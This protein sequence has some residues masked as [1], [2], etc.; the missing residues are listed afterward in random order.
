MDDTERAAAGGRAY[1]HGDLRHVLIETAE[2][3]LTERGVEGFSLRECARRAGVSP[4]APAHHF[5]NVTG[6]L[7]AIATLGFEGLCRAM[8][9]AA[10]AGATPTARL[11]GLGRG[12]IRYALEHPAR[13]RV[14]FGRFP[15]ERGDPALAQA[16][17][18]AFGLLATANEALPG[19]GGDASSLVLAWS[20]VHGFATLAL[21]GQMP[22]VDGQPD[23]AAAI[24]RLADGMLSLIGR[25]LGRDS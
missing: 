19:R 7:T 1:H 20:A 18:R 14:M 22:F 2:Q 16:G 12:Y 21:D 6:L 23:R 24:D 13:F 4:A 10:A 25:A 15:L 3:L 17:Q 8:E 9:E 11:R 5:G